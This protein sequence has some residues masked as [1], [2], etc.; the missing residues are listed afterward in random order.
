MY[1]HAKPD[2]QAGA[3]SKLN[4]IAAMAADKPADRRHNDGPPLEPDEAQLAEAKAWEEAA[5]PATTR[6]KFN[7]LVAE[8]LRAFHSAQRDM[9][10]KAVPDQR[11]QPRHRAILAA[12]T[13]LMNKRTGTCFPSYQRLAEWTG[14]SIDTVRVTIAELRRFGYLATARYAPEPGKKTL[15]H[16]TVIKPGKDEIFA[17]IAGKAGDADFKSQGIEDSKPKFNRDQG[18]EVSNPD[19]KPQDIEDSPRPDADFN[20]DPTLSSMPSSYTVTGR[21][22]GK[23]S[24]SASRE[25]EAAREPAGFERVDVTAQGAGHLNGTADLMT[26]DAIRWMPQR[27][28]TAARNWLTRLV[29]IHGQ[30][31]VKESWGKLC[32][33]IAAGM[34]IAQPL[35]T[36]S[37]I[38]TRLA[39]EKKQRGPTSVANGGALAAETRAERARRVALEEMERLK[40]EGKYREEP[41]AP[42]PSPA[43]ELPLTHDFDPAL[44]ENLIVCGHTRE[45]A[46][47]KAR[48]AW[49]RKGRSK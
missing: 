18:I 27:D 12:A 11:L 22:T 41:T 47:K 45:E 30:D 39:G 42:N 29:Q 46:L 23:D 44:V 38:A 36:W 7:A 26:A 25:S 2:H 15:A 8:N 49:A 32:T 5:T 9:L 31:V 33:D 20:V 28:P 17:S 40:A 35:Q 14:Y 16:Y 37:K 34:V 13:Y 1:Y 19:F 48:A 3:A 10:L 4:G 21:V 43:P 24:I 6:E